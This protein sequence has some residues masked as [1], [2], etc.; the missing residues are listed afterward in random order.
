VFCD[1]Q[2]FSGTKDAITM[3]RPVACQLPVTRWESK[4]PSPSG[5]DGLNSKS[6]NPLTYM[7]SSQS[8]VK[9]RFLHPIVKSSKFRQLKPVVWSSNKYICIMSPGSE[10]TEARFGL[11]QFH[12]ISV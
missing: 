9:S 4:A 7:K 3:F 6:A 10:R 11:S 1:L 5:I 12:K 2:I 8:A